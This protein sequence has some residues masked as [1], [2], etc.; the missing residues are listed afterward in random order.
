MKP[1]LNLLIAIV[2]ISTLLGA[3][4]LA[5]ASTP[6]HEVAYVEPGLWTTASE[7]LSLIVTAQDRQAAAEILERAGGQVSSDL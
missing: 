7:T 5:Q 2:M 4:N 3:M 6:T 1:V